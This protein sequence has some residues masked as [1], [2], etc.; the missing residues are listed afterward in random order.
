MDAESYELAKAEKELADARNDIRACQQTIKELKE[1]TMT[2]EA[3][4]ARVAE[5]H[6]GVGESVSGY[7]TNFLKTA[8]K[9][10]GDANAQVE[11][12]CK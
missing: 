1:L 7:M 10:Y 4:E 2:T 12:E 8:S 11:L 9:C 3:F 6:K 5:V